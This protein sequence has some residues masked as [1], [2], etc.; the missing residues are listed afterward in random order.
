MQSITRRL[1]AIVVLLALFLKV[2]Q[3]RNY[4]WCQNRVPAKTIT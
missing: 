1:T 2:P 4:R 3:L